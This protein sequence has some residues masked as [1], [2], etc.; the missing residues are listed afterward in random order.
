MRI[1]LF[2][3]TVFYTSFLVA[4]EDLTVTGFVVKVYDGDT[5]TVV[6]CGNEIY[7]IRFAK[8]DAPE[9]VQTFGKEAK[10]CLSDKILNKLVRVHITARDLYQ[11]Y[12]GEVF[13]DGNSVNEQLVEE[14]C[15]WVY[16]AYNKDEDLKVLEE[17]ARLGRK[18]LWEAEAP[19]P[20]WEWRK[21]KKSQ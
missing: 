3:L 7:K 15:A 1:A 11:R 2:I 13:V 14:G 4:A 21:L 5:A 20:P 18:G 8:I 10:M 6:S 17:K 19:M 12:V 9:L 16:D